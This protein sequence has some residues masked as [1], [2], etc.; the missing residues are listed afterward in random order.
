MIFLFFFL[1]LFCAASAVSL[2]SYAIFLYEN[3]GAARDGTS[4]KTKPYPVLR[5]LVSSIGCSLL[6]IFSYPL[7]FFRTFRRPGTIA[8]GQAVVILVHGLYHNA[9]AWLL[10]RRRLRKAGCE[11]IFAMNYSS[12]F[13]SFEAAAGG[14]KEFVREARAAAP[15]RPLILIGHSLGGLLARA[16]AERSTGADVPAMV[17]TLGTPHQGS[18]MAAFALGALG[19]SLRYRGPL[20]EGLERAAAH[21]PCPGVVFF[22]PVDNLVLPAEGLKAPYPGWAYQETPPLSHVAMLY[23]RSVAEKVLEVLRER[24]ASQ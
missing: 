10:F 16:Y 17:I 1:F 4:P 22:S 14:L 12:W 9:S 6:V 20:F 13:T 21:L 11:N 15:D 3:T 7:G 19:R 8:P 18:K 24:F 23:S 5:G 2:F